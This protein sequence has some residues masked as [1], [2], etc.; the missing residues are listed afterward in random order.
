MR[1]CAL[2]PTHTVS[3]AQAARPHRY[4]LLPDSRLAP[5]LVTMSTAA[6]DG[7]FLSALQP[8]SSVTTYGL[9]SD[10]RLGN[11]SSMSDEVSKVRRVQE[12]VQMRLAQK[13]TLPR[14]NGSASHYATSGK[15]QQ[16]RSRASGGR[17]TDDPFGPLRVGSFP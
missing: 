7:L 5:S 8:N 10:V 3:A 1:R 6:S 13:S 12:Q 11:G 15:H 14:Q 4:P 9:P 2:P 16:T 17:T